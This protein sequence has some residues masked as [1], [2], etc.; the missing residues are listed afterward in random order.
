MNNLDEYTEISE[1]S[2]AQMQSSSPILNSQNDDIKKYIL[3]GSLVVL[4]FIAIYIIFNSD[5][6]E[7]FENYCGDLYLDFSEEYQEK[8]NS[9]ISAAYVD[10]DNSG[11]ELLF[12]GGNKDDSDALLRYITEAGKPTGKGKLINQIHN[13]GLCDKSAATISIVPVQYKTNTL[14]DL[15]VNR[16]SGI[17]YYKNNHEVSSKKFGNPTYKFTRYDV[18]NLDDIDPSHPA[19]AYLGQEEV[20]YVGK[21]IDRIYF[22][23]K[24]QLK[25]ISSENSITNTGKQ[26]HLSE[27]FADSSVT[28]RSDIVLRGGMFRGNN[29]GM[30]SSYD[31][32]PQPPLSPPVFNECDTLD[33]AVSEARKN[34]MGL[35]DKADQPNDIVCSGTNSDVFVFVRVYKHKNDYKVS[36]PIVAPLLRQCGNL[37]TVNMNNPI[38]ETNTSPSTRYI[39]L[40]LPITDDFMDANIT[41][42]YNSNGNE[43]EI[44]RPYIFSGVGVKSYQPPI[45]HYCFDDDETVDKII[46][47]KKDK[48]VLVVNEPTM[49]QTHQLGF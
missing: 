39:N 33:D 27:Y 26:D 1:Q 23:N 40:Q 13:S 16:T 6:L 30:C 15:L 36:K 35:I 49:N 19:S 10:I 12:V 17:S 28:S 9:I 21:F 2:T 44:K 43:K 38:N 29:E 4:V 20:Y 22:L 34:I 31:A 3:I 8:K 25:S 11:N 48:V 5:L 32:V 41:I 7:P 45:L 37:I 42:K 14:T 18:F 47:N 46:I 24:N